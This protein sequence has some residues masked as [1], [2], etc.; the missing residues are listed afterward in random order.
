MLPAKKHLLPNSFIILKG[1]S[2]F[3]KEVFRTKSSTTISAVGGNKEIFSSVLLQDD[4]EKTVTINKI[5]D[6]FHRVSFFK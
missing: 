2:W 6:I 5:K 3:R 1:I 4:N